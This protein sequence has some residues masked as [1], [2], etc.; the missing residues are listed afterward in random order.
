MA[1]VRIPVEHLPP[2]NQNGDHVF[3]FR[4]ISEDRNR[5]SAWSNLYTIKSI[6]QYRPVQ[7]DY[8]FNYFNE[9]DPATSYGSFLLTWTT[10]IVYNFSASLSSASISHNHSQDFKQHDTDIF[11]QWDDESSD[12]EYYERVSSDSVTVIVPPNNER[13]FVKVIGLIATSRTPL[14]SSQSE[15]NNFML[16]NGDLFKVFETE[17][18]EVPVQLIGFG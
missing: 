7:S 12:Y 5:T 2:P 10:P 14:I 13:P 4:I 11:L 18:I 1:K 17:F 9:S 16:E 3:Q 6:G 8:I 15:L